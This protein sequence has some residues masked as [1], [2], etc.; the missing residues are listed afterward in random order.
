MKD[1]TI[2]MKINQDLMKKI[3]QDWFRHQISPADYEGM[4]DDSI[5]ERVSATKNG[6][7][8]ILIR[9]KQPKQPLTPTPL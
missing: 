5:V 2:D 7:F 8:R 1:W 6:Q 4:R 3:I 9:K